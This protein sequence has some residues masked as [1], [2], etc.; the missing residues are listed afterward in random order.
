MTKRT[1]AAILIL[2]LV[3]SVLLAI[4]YASLTDT[5]QINGSANVEPPPFVGVYIQ[6]VEIVSSSYVTSNQSVSV[7]P[8][9]MHTNLTVSR[10]GGEI[11]YAITVHN[12]SDVTY[13]YLGTDYVTNQGNNSL[14][15]ASGGIFITTNDNNNS[16]NLFDQ[17]DWVPPKAKRTFYATYRFGASAVG[18]NLVN[19]V[20]FKFGLQMNSVQDGFLNVL[21]DRVSEYGYYYLANAFNEQYAETGKTELGNI[22]D[23]LEIFNNIFGSNLSIN[24]DGVPTP[25]T[26]MISRRN[27]D[28]STSSGD[29]F[30]PQSG[31]TGC[32]YTI[33]VT[34]DPMNGQPATVYAVSYT[35]GAD[36]VWYQIGELY[37]GTCQPETYDSQ[38][39]IAFDISSW[40]A[41]PNTYWV[42]DDISYKV[43]Y[44]QGTEYD[45]YD[46]I[47]ELMAAKDQEFYNAVN[48]N[49]GKL[50]RP[51][52]L[53]LYS[54]RH[55]NGRWEE[56][57]NTDNCFNP[58]YDMLKVAFDKIKPYCY[59]GNG[60]QE[61]KL[62]NAN[63]LSRAE[64]ICLLESIQNAYDYYQSVN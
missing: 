54:Y 48:N 51:V 53:I 5:L 20:N 58:G 38:G 4:G 44:E 43:G 9:T 63:M 61:V 34:T 2:C 35:C 24:I 55:S 10:S 47:E 41:S 37:E 60:A 13:W 15:N 57:L 29:A 22:G 8:T 21:N 6:S 16:N 17:S 62:Q 14:L 27:I 52:C 11:T 59:I 45:K 23:D 46:T 19:L 30:T 25:V 7:H 42:T 18:F 12:N 33:Y 56:A 26:I 1:L 40:D 3:F 31:G 39:N 32:E 49:S 36:G 28:S 64:L 50:L